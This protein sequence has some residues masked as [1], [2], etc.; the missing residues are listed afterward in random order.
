MSHL[1][2]LLPLAL[3]IITGP[4]NCTRL[5]SGHKVLAS[6]VQEGSAGALLPT[7][8]VR[9]ETQQGEQVQHTELNGK[10]AMTS[11]AP[12]GPGGSN[13][14]CNFRFPNEKKQG[15]IF[16]TFLPVC[17]PTFGKHIA[18]APYNFLRMRNDLHFSMVCYFIAQP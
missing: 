6:A 5:T 18:R 10:S 13:S 8:T 3:S 17:H 15:I 4:S 9:P 7:S 11:S 1:H 2:D 12:G 16:G 14:C